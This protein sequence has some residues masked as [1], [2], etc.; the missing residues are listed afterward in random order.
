[1]WGLYL[2][3]ILTGSMGGASHSGAQGHNQ[4]GLEPDFCPSRVR[5]MQSHGGDVRGGQEWS[6]GT[7][8]LGV[9]LR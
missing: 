3:C 9:A 6:C 4:V 8:R 5:V 2:V 7:E 1:M